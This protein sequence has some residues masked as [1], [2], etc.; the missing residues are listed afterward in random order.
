MEPE[1]SILHLQVSAIYRSSQADRSSPCPHSYFLEDPSQYSPPI[2]TWVFQAVSSL[3]FP[4]QTLYTPLLFPIRATCAKYLILLVLIT[5][6]ILGEEYK[7][8]DS[9]LFSFKYFPL[10]FF[11]LGPNIIL[12]PLFSNTLYLRHSLNV[13]DQISHL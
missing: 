13:I 9:S 2:Y 10:T 8:L 11:L 1:S 7:S 5:R 6:K 12:N 4:H 3:R